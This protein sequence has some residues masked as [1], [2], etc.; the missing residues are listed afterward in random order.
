MRFF[1]KRQDVNLDLPERFA[2]IQ[3]KTT[4]SFVTETGESL[5][6]K[7]EEKFNIVQIALIVSVN[8]RW[9]HFFLEDLKICVKTWDNLTKAICSPA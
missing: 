8:D 9:C 7:L 4:S 1:D 2:E 6:C 3:H 5:K